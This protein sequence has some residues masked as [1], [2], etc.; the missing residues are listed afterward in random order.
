MTHFFADDEGIFDFIL[1]LGNI[2]VSL[3]D[4]VVFNQTL[5][6]DEKER[7]DK[8]RKVR[9]APVSIRTLAREERTK[10]FAN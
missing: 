7:L 5:L 4:K 6:S 1:K 8:E 9:L 3:F 2:D 10:A